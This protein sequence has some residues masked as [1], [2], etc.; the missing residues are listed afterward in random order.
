MVVRTF[1]HFPEGSICPLCGAN[2]D[3]PC[4]LVTIDNTQKGNI[5]EASPAHVQC[6]LDGDKLGYNKEAKLIYA[7]TIIRHSKSF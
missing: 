5:A 6:M 3:L 7:R 1:K 2:R 4:I